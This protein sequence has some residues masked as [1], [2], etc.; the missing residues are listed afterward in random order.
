MIPS[1]GGGTQ[2]W[3]LERASNPH[4]AMPQGILSP[5]RLPIPPSRPKIILV[6]GGIDVKILPFS[7]K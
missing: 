3:C 6:L 7:P 2:I 1:G 5:L 4:G